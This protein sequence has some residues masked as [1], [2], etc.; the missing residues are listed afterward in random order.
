[1]IGLAFALV[2]LVAVWAILGT[3]RPFAGIVVLMAVGVG[4]GVGVSILE[5]GWPTLILWVTVTLT[6]ALSLTVS[7]LVIRSCGYR[8]RRRSAPRPGSQSEE[9][10]TRV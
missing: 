3:K 6:E 5:P 4:S 10:K 1:M 8:L 9:I 7:L 2:G